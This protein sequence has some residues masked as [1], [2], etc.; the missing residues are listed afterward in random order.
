MPPCNCPT[1][2]PRR[3]VVQL[4][5]LYVLGLRVGE[6]TRL[7]IRDVDFQ[8]DLLI[9]R[10][11]RFSKT[12]L[13]PFG[14]SLC[15]SLKDYIR[16]QT[17]QY[18]AL[19]LE[20]PVFSCSRATA[21]HRPINTNTVSWTFHQLV[22]KLALDIPPGVSHRTCIACATH[23]PSVPCCTGIQRESIRRDV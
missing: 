3:T 2:Q 4:A 5:L 1:D 17:E 10:E 21:R 16:Q 11:T 7:Q 18:G 23:S 9:I 6:A 15:A 19:A 13:V 22:P 20:Q 14:P 12:R 8:R